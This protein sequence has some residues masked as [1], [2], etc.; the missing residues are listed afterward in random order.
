MVWRPKVTTSA[1]THKQFLS[2]LVLCSVWLDD[3][4][5]T[6]LRMLGYCKLPEYLA[7]CSLL[8]EH[9]RAGVRLLDTQ[10]VAALAQEGPGTLVLRALC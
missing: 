8:L 4:W 6:S 1:K 3:R 10:W 2:I 5:M 9:A 7:R